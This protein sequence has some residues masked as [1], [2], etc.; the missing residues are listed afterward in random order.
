MSCRFAV[1]C[2]AAIACCLTS[3]SAI[4]QHSF[5]Y[6]HPDIAGREAGLRAY[7]ERDYAAAHRHFI[8]AA[9]HADKGAQ[10]MLAELYWGGLG[11]ERDPVV[12]YIWADLAAERGYD[13]LVGKREHYWRSLDAAQRQRVLRIGPDYYADYGDDVAQA[14]L[15]ELLRDGHKKA[16]GTR[17]G[18]PVS[19]VVV[20]TNVV[21]SPL[22]A[23]LQSISGVR[24]SNYYMPQH[25]I[26]KDYWALQDR[27]WDAAL[28]P[29]GTVEVGS[30]RER[31]GTGR[32]ASDGGRQ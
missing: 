8:D 25:W 14:R 26:P 9:L 4:A 20:L 11:V 28:P 21:K 6:Y 22:Y 15:E 1:A 12:A 3:G 18:G 24:H 27:T 13:M 31:D 2:I 29:A 32:D 17:A 10:A 5:D 16:T 7:E 30:L 19:G 23:G